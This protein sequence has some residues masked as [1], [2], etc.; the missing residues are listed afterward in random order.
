MRIGNVNSEEK[1]LI[2]AEIGNNHEGDF[3]RA[4]EMIAAAAEAGVDAVKF[5]TIVPDRLVS[6]IDKKRIEQLERF[7]FSYDQYADLADV[8]R[9]HNVAFLSTPFDLESVSALDS[10]VPAFKIA[11]SDN[12]FYPLLKAVAATGKPLIIST[13]LA[14]L[15]EIT[16]AKSFIE[17]QWELMGVRQELAILHCVTS[18]PTVVHEANLRAIHTLKEKIGGVIGYSDHTL[19]IQASVLAVALGAR[20]IEKHFTLDKELSDFRD[21]QL[22]ADPQEMAQLVQQIEET[23]ALLGDGSLDPQDSEAKVMEQ[24]RRSIVAAHDLT[25]GQQIEESD[26]SWVRP[27]GGIAPGLESEVIGKKL[28]KA[29]SKGEKILTEDL[30]D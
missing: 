28:N 17:A 19:G 21:H 29:I 4:T 27:G 18:Y 13:G 23:S 26:L 14:D 3:G 6:V 11:S 7:R 2:I 1:V 24:V 10:I 22:S 9:E 30:R 16:E 25:D 15:K 20:I 5:Q 8:A 12:N